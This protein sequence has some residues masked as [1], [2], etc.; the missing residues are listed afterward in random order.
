MSKLA[1]SALFEYLCY[2]STVIINI[3]IRSGRGPSL[4]VR[5]CDVYTR[6]ILT[7]KNGPNNKRV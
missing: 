1:L 2:E 4:Y 5:K 6:Q 3:L 7:N